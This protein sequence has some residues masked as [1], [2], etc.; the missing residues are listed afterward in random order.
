MTKETMI[1]NYR[2]F[3]AADEYIL[4][5]IY[6]HQ[7]YML[8]MAEIPPRY[9]TKSHES[10]SQG[11]WENLMLFLTNPMKEQMIRK[12]AICLGSEDLVLNGEYNKGV[13]FER[14]VYEMNGQTFRGKDNVPFYMAGDINIDGVE[15]QIKFQ[16]AR[17]TKENT[18]ENLKKGIYWGAKAARERKTIELLHELRRKAGIE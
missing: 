2:K 7:L 14:L 9:I 12:G 1:K 18:I 10:Q 16:G 6:K 8:R 3:S 4:G 17:L 5:F 15:I 11:G 13:E